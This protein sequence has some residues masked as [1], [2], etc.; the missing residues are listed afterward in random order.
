MSDQDFKPS[1]QWVQ[2]F[3]LFAGVI[4]PIISITIEATT[5]ICAREFFDPIPSAW[6][7]LLVVFVPLAQLHVW[8]TVRRG[9][10]YF[11]VLAFLVNGIA[12]G[13]SIF[14]SIVYLPLAPVGAMLLIVGLG[15]LPLTPFFSLL[16]AIVMGMQLKR[17]ARRASVPYRFWIKG[18]GLVLGIAITAM[19]IALIELPASLTRY[20][21]QMALSSAPAKRAEGISF[22][23]S[24]GNKE[25]LLRT[26]YERTGW[27][28]DLGGYL[29]SASNP[30]TTSEARAIYYRVTGETFDTSIPPERFGG[31]VVPQ[32]TIDFDR[33]QGGTSVGQKLKGLSLA[34]SRLDAKVDGDGG[35]AY[36]EWMLTF[37]NDSG[38]Q[39]EA[40]AEV[41][42]PPGGVV[43]R[44]TLWVNGEEREAAFA[45]R[46]KVREAYQQVAIRQRK[47]PVLVTT[48]GRDRILVQC[49]PVQ[50]HDQMKIRIGITAPLLLDQYAHGRFLFPHFVKRNFRIPDD[51]QHAFW[52][53]SQTGM[54]SSMMATVS[55]WGTAGSV[56]HG[57]IYDFELSNPESSITVGRGNVNDTWSEDPFG[58]PGFVIQQSIQ[59]RKPM[60]LK[61]IVVVIDTSAAMSPSMLEILEG[62]KTLGEDVDLQLVFTNV[63]EMDDDSAAKNVS[64]GVSSVGLALLQAKFVGGA[65]NV[66]AL[67]QAWDLAASKPGNNAI[68]WVHSPQLLELRPVDE[69]R[70]RW[71]RRPYGPTL[72]SIQTTTGSDVVEAKLDGLNEVKSVPRVGPLHSDLQTLFGRL[73]GELRTFEF[74]RISRRVDP[75]V[76]LLG[77]IEASDHLARLWAKDEVGRILAARDEKL[78]EAATMLA[79]RYQLVTPVS[80]AVVLETAEQYRAAG[81]QPVD[82]GTVP[83][84]PEPEMVILVVIAG[85][86]LAWLL[87]RKRVGRGGCPV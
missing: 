51:V 81:L 19:T 24:W 83:T 39:R 77:S 58:T 74:V 82:A 53:E 87:Y 1:R 37:Q 32:D 30:M 28:T 62:L 64:S 66:P 71:E 72:Y 69:L 33:D 9:V 31:R 8:F 23:R 55:D 14:Y 54:T 2:F 48:A 45:G 36:T 13:I 73:R 76:D 61:R 46:S 49:F 21:L 52:I 6:H 17:V 15:A 43:S 79:V 84:I 85:L 16:A 35:V 34:S 18:G 59:D 56:L 78:N 40:R 75:G 47:D 86:F 25:Y 12:I 7:L 29:L 5:H 44:L 67:L 50:P 22:L 41:Q 38:E 65:D 10:T 63:E 80:G 57:R 11:P 70:Q 4:L 68:V 3:N 27:A 60:H 42:L 26:C 20:G